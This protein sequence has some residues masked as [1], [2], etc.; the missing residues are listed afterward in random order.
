V[1]LDD[2]DRPYDGQ[3]RFQAIAS[4]GVMA[5]MLFIRGVTEQESEVID[6][7]RKR[8][9][10]DSYRIQG[11]PDYKRRSVV[12]RAMAMY[13]KY[14]IEGVRNPSGMA[15]TPK[16]QDAWVDAPGMAEAIKAGEALARAVKANPSHAA[17]A[18]LRTATGPA[19]EDIDADG[20]WESV[21]SGVGL[22]E[23]DPALTL[24][25]SL[26]TGRA[27]FSRSG[28]ADPRLFEIYHLTVA[29]NHHV[30]GERWSKPNP[31]FEE[32]AGQ[33]FFPASAV[34]DFRPLRQTIAGKAL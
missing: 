1:F 30:K 11:I 28:K 32:K 15:L 17:Y 3:H 7:G 22:A 34:P 33:K 16:E 26:L 9:R 2:S 29:W 13:H 19:V 14:G 21:R 24:R 5:W 8:T 31:K 25:N 12:S 27:R 18:V 20:F 10:A 4:S 6:T 23:A